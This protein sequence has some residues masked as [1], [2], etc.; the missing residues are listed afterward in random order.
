MVMQMSRQHKGC[1]F[2]VY[3]EKLLERQWIRDRCLTRE[4]AAHVGC[5]VPIPRS[6]ISQQRHSGFVLSGLAKSYYL[7]RPVSTAKHAQ[8][9][10]CGLGKGVQHETVP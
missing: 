1:S 2:S 5:C 9:S 8:Q 7:E 6:T 4:I 3:A 10:P